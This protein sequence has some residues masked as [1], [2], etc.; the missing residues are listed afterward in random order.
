M[1]RPK[2]TWN[3]QQAQTALERAKRAIKVFEVPDGNKISDMNFSEYA[4]FKGIEIVENPSGAASRLGG[5]SINKELYI[6]IREFLP[7]GATILELGSG[8]GTQVLSHHY[9]MFSIE[10]DRNFFGKYNSNYIYA[11]IKNGWY[12]P[13]YLKGTLP[14]NYDLILVDA[15]SAIWGND[16]RGFFEHRYL[17]DLSKP[18]IVDDTNRTNE[19][20]LV[21]LILSVSAKPRWLK[22]FKTFTVIL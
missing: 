13:N 4:N 8:L 3:E 10:D 2:K 19:R 9:K 22:V 17:F 20:K 16:R 14:T 1:G 21:K 6:F 5:W 15:P 12:D 7:R 11:P 18:I